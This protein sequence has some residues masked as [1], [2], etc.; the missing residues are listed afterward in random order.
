MGRRTMMEQET[1]QLLVAILSHHAM[2]AQ[3]LHL[4]K[5]GLQRM[6]KV[7]ALVVMTVL[8]NRREAAVY[9]VLDLGDGNS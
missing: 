8:S 9:P 2:I 6:Q 4:Y 3:S 1:I 5:L 7:Q